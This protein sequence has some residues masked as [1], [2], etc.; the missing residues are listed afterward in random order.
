MWLRSERAL[1]MSSVAWAG[2][3]PP[4][5]DLTSTT[6]MRQGAGAPLPTSDGGAA[7]S[8]EVPVSVVGGTATVQAGAVAET[9]LFQPAADLPP[10]DAPP[11][12]AEQRRQRLIALDENEVRG[13]TKCRLCETR[14][15]TVFGEGDP[16]A[17]LFFIG[18]GPGGNEDE[19]G[20]P[21][22]GR[23]GDLL[24]KM[25]GAMGLSRELVY[26]ANI[27]KCRAF[28]PGP[29][30]KDRA[31]SPDEVATCTPYLQ[32]QLEIIRPQVIVTLGLPA[33]RY[34]LQTSQ[35]MGQLRGRWHQWRGIKVMP[36]Y[37]PAYVLRNYSETTRAAV[38]GD[39]KQV[40]GELG[41]AGAAKL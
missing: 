6:D 22:V 9:P 40:M 20:R 3:L 35:S 30:P 12:D 21:F 25:I 41:L 14:N 10:F 36:T 32:R 5:A 8:R 33:S 23:A 19:T 24:N 7:S 39:L 26:I 28:L 38:W 11:L 2:P 15:K 4:A 18:E 31:P 27:V 16:A 34:M 29:P 13:C 1:G 37:H 17:R